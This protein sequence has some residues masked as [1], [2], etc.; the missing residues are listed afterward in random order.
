MGMSLDHGGHLT[1]G[2][3]V[4]IS[5]RLYTSSCRTASRR[6]TS[7]RLRHPR[8]GRRCRPKLIGGRR[9]RPLADDD[10]GVWRIADRV[11]P[12]HVRL[13]HI[14]GLIAGGVHPNPVPLRRHRHV[15]DP[16][17]PCAP[18]AVARSSAAPN[19]PPPAST[20]PSSP[21]CRVSLEHV[22]AARRVASGEAATP[23][24]LVRRPD[25]EERRSSW[26]MR[27]AAGFRL[28]SGGADNHLMLV[29]LRLRRRAGPARPRRSSTRPGS[30]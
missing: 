14:A 17:R 28:V 7:A 5:G 23:R 21:A 10:R 8:P 25:R 9:D 4:N 2:S 18:P 12:V 29:D 16:R 15:H 22:I 24:S 3:P 13:A 26:P 1:H 30:P 27:S 6:A 11:A 20:R 19:T